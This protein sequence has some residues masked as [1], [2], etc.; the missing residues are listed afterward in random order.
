MFLCLQARAAMVVATSSRAAMVVVATVVVA[1][2]HPTGPSHASM[3]E[4]CPLAG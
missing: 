4:L 3:A 2:K 1:T